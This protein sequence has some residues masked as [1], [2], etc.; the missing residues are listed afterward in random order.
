MTV[1]E[2]SLGA[3][4]TFSEWS[5]DSELSMA[6][7]TT[8]MTLA[9]P[10]QAVP[11]M[12]SSPATS[13]SWRAMTYLFISSNMW[14]SEIAKKSSM[15][16][17]SLTEFGRTW[18]C[19]SHCSFKRWMNSWHDLLCGFAAMA[20][21]ALIPWRQRACSRLTDVRTSWYLL[22]HL[23]WNRPSGYLNLLAHSWKP[24]APSFTS[25]SI[26]FFAASIRT[27]RGTLVS[28]NESD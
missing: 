4:S 26:P 28:R 12:W 11:A 15:E 14:F 16:I 24:W 17:T 22:H 27:N 7:V 18:T 23:N 6:E 13:F 10:S 25:L 19:L 3:F 9:A 20:N 2:T 21:A 8:E 1:L 5:P